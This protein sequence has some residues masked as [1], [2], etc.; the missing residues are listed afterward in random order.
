MLQRGDTVPHFEITTL[1]GETF[2]YATIWQRKNL[3]FVALSD[4]DARSTQDYITGLTA[5]REELGGDDAACVITRDRVAGM[6]APGVVIADRWGEVVYVVSAP[7]VGDLPAPQEL[8]EWVEYL[9]TRCP[10]CEGESK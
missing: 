1:T 8:I 4:Q 7:D 10:E 6:P 2:S 3:I 9:E 5:R